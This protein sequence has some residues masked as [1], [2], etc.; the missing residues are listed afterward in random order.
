VDDAAFLVDPAKADLGKRTFNSH[1]F[2]CH[3]YNLV[4]GGAAPDLRKSAVPLSKDALAAVV[5]DGVLQVNGMPAFDYLTPEQIEGI[6]HYVR[7]RARESIA[8]E[9]AQAK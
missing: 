8:A 7:L 2:L 3:G 5:H 4:S 6:Q 1:C 9:T